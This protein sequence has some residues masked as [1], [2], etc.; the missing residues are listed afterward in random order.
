[1]LSNIRLFIL[2][3]L[4]GKEGEQM[5]EI[6]VTLIIKGIRTFEHVPK[7]LQ[8]KVKAVLEALDLGDLAQ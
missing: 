1:M 4:L 6:Y 5:V 7:V 2:K 8:P 3:I